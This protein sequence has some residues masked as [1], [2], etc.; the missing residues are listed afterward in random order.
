MEGKKTTKIA[1]G[2][3]RHCRTNKYISLQFGTTK[4]WWAIYDDADLTKEFAN[5]FDTKKEAAEYLWDYDIQRRV[6]F[7]KQK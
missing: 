6:D 5:G 4:N 2:I 7:W 1:K 3:Y